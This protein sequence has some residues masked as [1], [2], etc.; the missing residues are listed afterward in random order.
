MPGQP[1]ARGELLWEFVRDADQ[2]CFRCE[3]RDC[4]GYGFDVLILEQDRVVYA[5]MFTRGIDPTRTPRQ[6]A[7]Q[8]AAEERR[9]LHAEG[10]RLSPA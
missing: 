3:L 5:R 9:L 10:A 7:V 2:K 1:A 6:L 8:W 4:G